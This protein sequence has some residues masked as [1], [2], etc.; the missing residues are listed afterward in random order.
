MILPKPDFRSSQPQ[1]SLL[2]RT[3]RG[4]DGAIW[5]TSDVGN[6]IGRIAPSGGLRT[7]TLP[8]Q[9]DSPTAITAGADGAIWFTSLDIGRITPTGEFTEISVPDRRGYEFNFPEAITT[10]PDG[11]I[12]FTQQADDGGNTDNGS[13][14]SQIGK[15]DLPRPPTTLHLPARCPWQT[16][17][18]AA[19]TAIRA[20][21]A[22]T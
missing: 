22:L 14:S 19:L 12:W 17:Y 15:I 10:G 16:D 3:F 18:I 7:Y 5:F 11:P 6:Q 20:L 8:N 13:E 9:P 21:P 2:D 4:A 1:E